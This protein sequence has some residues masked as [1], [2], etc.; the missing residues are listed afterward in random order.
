[1]A[2]EK[3]RL[4]KKIRRKRAQF[5]ASE[6]E[7]GVTFMDD[8]PA[9]AGELENFHLFIGNGGTR[10]GLGS[11]L[12]A[13]L[14]DGV[15]AL[16]MPESRDFSFAN[17]TGLNK[18]TH[19]L[20]R[21]N[22][23]CVQEACKARCLGHLL[24]PTLLEGPP[25]HL[26]ISLVHRIPAVVLECE[27]GGHSLPEGLV[28][29]TEF[30]SESEERKLIDFFTASWSLDKSENLHT[31]DSMTNHSSETTSI[32]SQAAFSLTQTP[33]AVAEK[34][35]ENVCIGAPAICVPVKASLRHR[36]VSHYGYEFL[37]G[38][39][40]VNPNVPL[41]GGL[42]DVCSPLLERMISQ[43]LLQYLPDQLTVNDYLPGAG[44]LPKMGSAVPLYIVNKGTK[45]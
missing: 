24:N 16:Y 6:P 20:T 9:G 23:L 3:G 34:Q 15:D 17:V 22:G 39:N 33:G 45:T 13:A 36:T 31:D 1:M 40:T 12:L 18:V 11:E 19:I 30:V 44:E 27:S 7:M 28:L 8:I 38:R 29:V 37:Y 32:P 42:P 2:A 25:L 21:C 43:E 10:C 14:L 35:Y 5:R 41:P 26:Y 4:L